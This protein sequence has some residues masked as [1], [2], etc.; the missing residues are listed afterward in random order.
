MIDNNWIE[1]LLQKAEEATQKEQKAHQNPFEQQLIVE[2][3]HACYALHAKK[4]SLHLGRLLA[5]AFDFVVTADYYAGIGHKGW[6]YCPSPTPRLYYHFTNCCPR[7]ALENMFYFHASSKPES[8]SIGKATSRLLR[9]FLNELLKH[10]RRQE[11]ILKGAEPVDIVIVNQAKHHIFFGE[12]KASPLLT[13]PLAMD[14]EALTDAQN[15]KISEHD[16]NITINLVYQRP[17]SVFV[18]ILRQKRW[19]ENS[20]CF[21]S[22]QG[23]DD[24]NW[25]YR[26]MLELLSRSPEFLLVY[27]EFWDVALSHYHPKV[28]ESIYWLTNGCGAPSPRPEWWPKS[29]GGD[30][31][32]F[33]T[34]SDSKTSVGM[35][36]TDDIKKG[37]Y[38][39]LKTWGRRKACQ[40]RMEV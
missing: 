11:V 16:G 18:P 29:K 34:V 1:T 20:F 33:E 31:E 38:Q 17:F 3:I 9:N 8:G 15:N 4:R 25:S 28:T 30:G 10:S 21:G 19:Q 6:F 40:K 27:Y 14:S 22:K 13:L 26:A 2:L 36:R 12:I 32:G 35:D 23:A 7:H 37:I 39:I 5:S 24:K